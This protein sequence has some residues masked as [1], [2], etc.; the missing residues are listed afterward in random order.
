MFD[1]V[2]APTLVAFNSPP[3]NKSIVGIPLTPYF[4]GVFGSLSMLCLAITIS[5]AISSEIS[6]NV[7]PICLQGPLFLVT[8]DPLTKK[9]RGLAAPFS[10]EVDQNWFSSLEYL[11]FKILVCYIYCSHNRSCI[12]D[13]SYISMRKKIFFKLINRKIMHSHIFFEFLQQTH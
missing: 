11:C 1:L 6:S 4:V 5:F 8:L 10:P 3:E 13:S 12:F 9:V 7:G 2:V